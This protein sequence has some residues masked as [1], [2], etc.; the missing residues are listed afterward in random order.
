VQFIEPYPKSRAV[1]LHK[2][3]IAREFVNW[4]PPSSGGAK[5]LFRPFVGVAP[6]LY[7]RAFS[8]DRE[9]KNNNNGEIDLQQPSWTT[10]WYLRKHGYVELEAELAKEDEAA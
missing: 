8:K 7:R 9:L 3:A 2:D 5:V 10:P 6:R 4:S 1:G